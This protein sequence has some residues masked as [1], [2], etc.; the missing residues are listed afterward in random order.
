MRK[1]EFPVVHITLALELA[2][3]AV[4]AQPVVVSVKSDWINLVF[5]S[6]Q[7]FVSLNK[8]VWGNML[9]LFYL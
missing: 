3:K 2:D 8:L 5:W 6:S 9:A 1:K 7:I 4:P